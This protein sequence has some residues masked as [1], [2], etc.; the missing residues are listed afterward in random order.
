M[1]GKIVWTCPIASFLFLLM[2]GG[3]GPSHLATQSEI[4]VIERKVLAENFRLHALEVD[5]AGALYFGSF[6]EIVKLH[7]DGSRAFALKASDHGLRGIVDFRV[8]PDGTVVIAGPAS[9]SQGDF[10][11]NVLMVSPQGKL[12]RSF[13]LPRFS[14]EV[15]EV[16]DRGELFLLGAQFSEGSVRQASAPLVIYQ[17]GVGGE[18]L[19]SLEAGDVA[20]VGR[21]VSRNRR[22]AIRGRDLFVLDPARFRLRSFSLDSGGRVERSLLPLPEIGTMAQRSGNLRM[23]ADY[24][25]VLGSGELLLAISSQDMRWSRRELKGGSWM[26]HRPFAHVVHLFSSEGA[27]VRSIPVRDL[28][29]LKAVGRDGFLYFVQNITTEE[30]TRTEVVKAALR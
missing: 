6:E 17:L 22:L 15:V 13:T 5:R 25:A 21:V 10:A 19:T 12:V 30:G 24:F 7:P 2:I 4:I 11:T 26:V 8:A 28:G 29:L 16:G 3:R 18:R 1:F 27:H 14:V 20:R 23:S 9:G